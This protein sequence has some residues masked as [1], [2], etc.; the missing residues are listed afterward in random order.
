[1]I[2]ILWLWPN[3]RSLIFKQLVLNRIPG[4]KRRGGLLPRKSLWGRFFFFD[5]AAKGAGGQLQSLS[6][7][8][9]NHAPL[10]PMGSRSDAAPWPRLPLPDTGV[11]FSSLCRAPAG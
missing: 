7:K 9:G 4:K 3:E 1:M 10:D 6:Q 2:G 5:V 8:S 11:Y